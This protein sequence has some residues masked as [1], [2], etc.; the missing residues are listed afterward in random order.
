MARFESPRRKR[1]ARRSRRDSL[2]NEAKET[3]KPERLSDL[4]FTLTPPDD[5]PRRDPHLL[6]AV[7][8]I[9]PGT[10]IRQAVDD[11]IRSREGALIV[12]GDPPELAFLYSRG[13]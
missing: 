8:T 7:E 6:A 12:V 2:P 3:R 5:D 1:C 10:P 11:V 13:V 4:G 9:A